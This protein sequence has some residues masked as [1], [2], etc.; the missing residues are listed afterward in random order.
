MT[1]HASASKTSQPAAPFLPYRKIFPADYLCPIP[2]YRHD[3]MLQAAPVNE[4]GHLLEDHFAD[5]PYTLVDTGGFVFYDPADMRR[6]RVRPDV[7]VVFGVDTD[8]IYARDGY[9]IAEA[10]KP[11]D[12]ALEVAS[13]T[14]SR[15]DTG[16]KRELYEMI[17]VGEYW[18]FDHTGGRLYGAALSGDLLVDGAYQP[19][20]LTA[21]ADG[22]LWGYSAALDLCLC[23]RGRRLL[24][25]D[26]KRGAYINNIGE[27]KAAHRQTAAE[28]DQAAAE[29][30]QATAERDTERA[31]RLLTA[32]ERDEVAMERDEVAVQRDAAV[33]EAARL[34]EELRRLRGE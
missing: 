14:T 28:R 18:R 34:R 16:E 25:Y 17:G 33:A 19:I 23:A 21:E 31:A 32:M 5:Q 11:P 12:F 10:G 3:D 24:Y 7:Y 9:I 22:L 13:R 26:R 27:E 4:S 8:A 20:P 30:D 1:T 29:R 6:R 2:E 15:Y